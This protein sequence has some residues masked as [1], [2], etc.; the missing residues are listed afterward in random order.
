MYQTAII[1]PAYNPPDAL[2]AYTE[3]LIRRGFH[4]ILVVD[5]GSEEERRHVF[6]ALGRLDEVTVFRHAVNLGKGRALKNAFNYVLAN[7]KSEVQGVITVDSDGQ[8][9]VEDVIRLQDR[10][11]LQAQAPS[12]ILGSRDFNGKEVPFKSRYGN[13]LTSLVFRLLYGTRVCDTQTGLRA[14]PVA[15]LAEYCKLDGERFEYEM[16]MLIYAALHRQRIE[17][18]PIRTVYFDHNSE[19]HFRP[20]A[21]SIRIYRVILKGFFTYILSSAS[22]SMLDLALFGLFLPVFGSADDSLRIAASTVAARAL[23]SV[24]NFTVNK[25]VVFKSSGKPFGQM[26]KYYAL[27]AVQTLLSA[28]AVSAVH[29]MLKGNELAEK[30]VVDSILFL[31]SYQVQRAWVFGGDC[32]KT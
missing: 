2:L 14:V 21:D 26:G 6:G 28:C 1:I 25:R 29:F 5:D 13:K 17:A 19:T 22:A 16:N 12:L 20:V 9:T 8:H 4:R 31:I 11:I 23:S 18:R 30:I 15:F 24:Y 3:A 10:L 32:P 7:W 27:C